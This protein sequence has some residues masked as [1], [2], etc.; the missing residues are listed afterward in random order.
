M[1]LSLENHLAQPENGVLSFEGV[2]RKGDLP[3]IRHT[4]SE[5]PLS[6]P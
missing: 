4:A 5:T 6:G 2:T 3:Y 1:K